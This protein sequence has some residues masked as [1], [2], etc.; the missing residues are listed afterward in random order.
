MKKCVI[1]GIEFEESSGNVF[2]DLGLPDADEMLVKGQLA[3]KI[4]EIIRARRWTQ[5]QAAEVIGMPQ[6]KL[7]RMLRGQFQGISQAKML[8]C[9]NLLGRDVQIVVGPARRTRAR[10]AGRIEVVFA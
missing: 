4:E 9:L 8:E 6:P 7:S 2:A 3:M 5:Q 1:N 10:N